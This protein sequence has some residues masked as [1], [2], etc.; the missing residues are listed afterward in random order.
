M[1]IA[2]HEESVIGEEEKVRILASMIPL[3]GIWIAQKYPSPATV[4]GRIIGSALLFVY[5]ISLWIAGVESFLSL[6]ILA[7]A[8]L[9]FVVK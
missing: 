6:I 2:S 9:L 8:I 5:I 4:S 7:S 3:I 1:H